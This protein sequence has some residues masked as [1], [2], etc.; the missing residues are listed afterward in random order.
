MATDRLLK[1]ELYAA[2]GIEWCL[3]VELV[4]AAPPTVTRGPGLLP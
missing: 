1:P 3:R 4:T 2:A